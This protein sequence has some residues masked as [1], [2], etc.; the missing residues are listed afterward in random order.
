MVTA[1]GRQE[2]INA[3]NTGTTPVLI[4][5]IGL[6]T[7]KD[8]P[9][10]SQ[11]ELQAEF[12]RLTTV[13]GDLIADDT[14]HVSAVDDSTD[15]YSY[16]E[17]GLYTDSGTLF[18]VYSQQTDITT[19]SAQ[20]NMLLSADVVLTRV[21]ATSLTFGEASFTN[22]PASETVKGVV[23]LATPG[24]TKTG[25]DPVR[26][27][28]VAALTPLWGQFS[29]S[30]S[31]SAS[32]ALTESD[33]NK[34]YPVVGASPITLPAAAGIRRGSVIGFTNGGSTDV[35]IQ[36][37]GTDVIAVNSGT[38]ASFVLAP[39]DFALLMMSD[40]SQWRVVSG[41]SLLQ[42]SGAFASDKAESGYQSLPGG[43]IFQWF[44]PVESPNNTTRRLWPIAFPNGFL[45]AAVTPNRNGQTFG[46]GTIF[47]ADTQGIIFTYGD[48]YGSVSSGYVFAVGY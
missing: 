26:V 33:L 34:F 28:P 35:T 7:G 21:D 41:S 24:E 14:I 32:V 45:T 47:D 29:D 2:I 15:E 8:D 25:T 20:G 6:G 42:H 27:P 16:S 19:K 23:E 37:A 11:T 30:T 44:R 39:G 40:S 22:P 43:L 12:K 18:A 31:I 13:A 38:I 10:E 4:S 48:D 1:A 46:G 3:E 9:S 5:E 36:C 17:F